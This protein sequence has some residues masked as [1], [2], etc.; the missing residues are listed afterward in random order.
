MNAIAIVVACGR[1]EEVAPDAEAG[2]LT[3][4]GAPMLVH[5]LKTLEATPSIDG[6]I[7]AITKKRVDSMVHLIKR[8]GFTK[9]KGVVVGGVNRQST[10]KTVLSKL[11]DPPPVIVIHEASRPFVTRDV[12]E[13]T[14][15][16]AKRYGC[17]IAAHKLPDAVKL[18]PK[19]FKATGTLDRNTAWVAETPQAFKSDVLD[20]IL[21]SKGAK[22][23]DDES[24]LVNKPGEVHMVE[25]GPLNMKIRTAKDLAVAT[26][27]INAKVV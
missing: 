9:I 23:V 3:L 7:I 20:K 25:A 19:G 10:L 12:L 26:A 4:G 16:S 17:A 11:P 14:L 21:K 1:E 6:V 24:A 18:S 13:E 5:S 2:F 15:K 8:F 22:I 27:L